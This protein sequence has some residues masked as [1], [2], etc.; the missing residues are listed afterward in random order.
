M[1]SNNKR[2][3]GSIAITMV[4]LV[5][6]L[7]MSVSMSYHK[8]IQTEEMV[9]SYSDYSDRAIDA[10]FSGI[11][12]AMSEVQSEKKVFSAN[13]KVLFKTN[14]TS[15]AID[16][17]EKKSQ[18]LYLNKNMTFTNYKDNSGNFPPYRFIVGTDSDGSKSYV[19]ASNTFYIKSV[20]EYF[21]YDG[22][23]KNS[24]ATYTAE[25]LA[26]CYI[27]KSTKTIRLLR[28]KKLNPYL[29]NLYSFTKYDQ[30]N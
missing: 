18:W 29:K 17:I 10:A 9:Q 2:K 1:I 6:C 19:P 24:I 14:P 27:D 8:M 25:L 7:L 12:Y 15:T 3:Q 13:A 5:F 23:I 16:K 28:Y 21:C 30:E 22:N 11:N 4:M 20:G 26:E